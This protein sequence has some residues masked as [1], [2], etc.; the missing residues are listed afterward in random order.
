MNIKAL[1]ESALLKIKLAN[2]EYKRG[3]IEGMVIYSILCIASL[4]FSILAY[5]KDHSNFA[6]LGAGI[7]LFIFQDLISVVIGYLSVKE[8]ERLT[9]HHINNMA[10]TVS[11]KSIQTEISDKS[12]H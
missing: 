2:L 11:N 4:V 12:I 9:I 5:L 8:Q 6:V 1:K 10:D 3:C 7:F